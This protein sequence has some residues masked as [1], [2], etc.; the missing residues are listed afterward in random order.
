MVESLLNYLAP[1]DER[2]VYWLTKP[3]EGTPWRNTTGDRRVTPIHDAREVEPAPSL[4]R[5]GFSLVHHE[6]AVEDLYDPAAVRERYYPEIEQLVA[7]ARRDGLT[8]VT[9]E[10]DLARLRG[11][12]GMPAWAQPIVPFAVTLQFEDA[13]ALRRL[14]S[15]RLFKARDGRS[16]K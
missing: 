3:P 16:R 14:V 1:M 8:L 10:K 15:D 2:P 12:Q 6:T 7:D 13:G 4:D 9:T 11:P 5:E